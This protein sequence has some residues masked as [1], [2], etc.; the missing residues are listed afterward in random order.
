MLIIKCFF[1]VIIDSK[2]EFKLLEVIENGSLMRLEYN[3]EIL[4]GVRE[5]IMDDVIKLANDLEKS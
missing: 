5:V 2:R 1:V 3:K 4:K